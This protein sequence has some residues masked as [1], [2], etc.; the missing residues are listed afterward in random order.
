[1]GDYADF[2][3][4][5]TNEY[6]DLDEYT[7]GLEKYNPVVTRNLFY[8]ICLGEVLNQ[9][10]CLEHKLGHG[11]FSS[12]WIALDIQNGTNVALKILAEGLGGN[13][14]HMQEEIFKT[15]RDTSHLTTYI[16]TFVLPGHQNNHRVLVYPLRGPGLSIFTLLWTIWTEMA[17]TF[18]VDLLLSTTS[19]ADLGSI[20]NR[21]QKASF[22]GLRQSGMSSTLELP[23]PNSSLDL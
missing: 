19:I 7:E 4:P 6:D 20:A 23:A 3:D 12:V 9:R 1:M 17:S 15:V 14:Y 16:D 11:G 2:P 10:Y 21:T 22:A 8:P 18:T 13:E 5:D